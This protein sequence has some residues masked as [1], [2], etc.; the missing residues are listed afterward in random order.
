MFA[1]GSP[2][3]IGNVI[4][5]AFEKSHRFVARPMEDSVVDGPNTETE[6]ANLRKSVFTRW[7]LLGVSP[8]TTS[9]TRE[10]DI[11]LRKMFKAVRLQRIPER[12]HI[13]QIPDFVVGT[14]RRSDG[15]NVPTRQSPHSQ[16]ASHQ[17]YENGV[18][19][20]SRI[21]L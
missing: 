10:A 16:I 8:R 20:V 3:Y 5:V 18:H 17:S 11:A 1:V 6:R 13:K 7:V 2:R 21:C 19:E 15:V 14:S 9:T 4:F 12:F